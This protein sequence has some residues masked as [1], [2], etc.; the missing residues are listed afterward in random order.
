M[1]LAAFLVVYFI[2]LALVFSN[3]GHSRRM[4]LGE[5]PC[6]KDGAV[7]GVAAIATGPANAKGVSAPAR[8]LRSIQIR[9]HVRIAAELACV[10]PVVKMKAESGRWGFRILDQVVHRL[11]AVG[12]QQVT[13]LMKT[14]RSD[15]RMIVAWFRVA[16]VKPPIGFHHSD[17]RPWHLQDS[18][19]A[20]CN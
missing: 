1:S 12:P 6:L 16:V 10:L 20:L 2:A 17:I 11:G 14:S 8:T 13:D 7:N 3:S 18:R 15:Q 19:E 9:R 4:S 5:Q